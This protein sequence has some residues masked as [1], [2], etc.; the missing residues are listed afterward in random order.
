MRGT[1]IAFGIKNLNVS[2]CDEVES[3][4]EDFT[5][6]SDSSVGNAK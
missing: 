4:S 1:K 6:I 5:L 2:V 3:G